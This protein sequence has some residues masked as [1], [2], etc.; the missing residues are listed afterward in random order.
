MSNSIN[1]ERMLE[2]QNELLKKYGEKYGK[3]WIEC[4]PENGHYS[5]LWAIGEMGEIIDII[6][7]QGHD[8]VMNDDEVRNDFIKEVVDVMM[9][10]T[11]LINCFGITASEFTK[12]Y[13]EKHEYN[14]KRW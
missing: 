3:E 6:K 1:I 13:E 2:I 9:Y 12:V 14:M 5:L 10:M 4:K 11:D 8:T 7:K